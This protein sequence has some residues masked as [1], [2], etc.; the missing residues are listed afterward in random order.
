M[1]GAEVGENVNINAGSIKVNYDGVKKHKTFI[2]DNKFIGCKTNLVAPINIEKNVFI[3]A[4]STVTRDVP[5]G[6]LAITRGRQINKSDYFNN[7][8]KPKWY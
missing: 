3:A 1:R 6:S 8:I 4:G 7:L 2:W 5:E